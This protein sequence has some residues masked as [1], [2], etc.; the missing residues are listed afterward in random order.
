[1]ADHQEPKTTFSWRGAMLG[2]I[3]YIVLVLIVASVFILK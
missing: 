1:M 3:S 2:L